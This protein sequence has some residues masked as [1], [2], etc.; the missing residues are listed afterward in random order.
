MRDTFTALNDLALARLAERG[1]GE[2]RTAHSA[3]F[4]HLDETGTTVSALAERAQVTKQ[5][6][7]ELVG[8]LEARGYVTR[9]PDPSD[10][11]AKL[12]L[13]TPR[14]REAVA[15]AQELVPEL[16]VR[17]AA[18]LGSERVADLRA[19]LEAILRMAAE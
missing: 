13:P 2:V 12:V 17:I 4:Q 5:A 14:G 8:Y 16:E 3:V 15:V 18:L 11:R 1:F 7:A 6:M 9:V 10:G 19:D